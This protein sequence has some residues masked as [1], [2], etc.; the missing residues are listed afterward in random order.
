MEFPVAGFSGGLWAEC[1][2]AR[3]GPEFRDAYGDPETLARL[4][5]LSPY[6]S[7]RYA[8]YCVFCVHWLKGETAAQERYRQAALA[9]IDV[10][11]V[12]QSSTRLKR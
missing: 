12:L 7:Y 2:D 10:L 9:G 11:E 1:L 8:H 3:T 4:D 5:L 6:F